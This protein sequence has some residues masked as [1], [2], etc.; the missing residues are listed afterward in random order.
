MC[1]EN[2]TN[3]MEGNLSSEADIS[4]AGQVNFWLF[5]SRMFIAK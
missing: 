3:A 5:E 4:L 2:I 1:P